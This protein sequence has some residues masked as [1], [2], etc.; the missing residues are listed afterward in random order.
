VVGKRAVND[1]GNPNWSARKGANVGGDVPFIIEISFKLLF[2]SSNM[3]AAGN[4]VS[5][6]EYVRTVLLNQFNYL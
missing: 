6:E 4:K 5:E 2:Q 1:G 3:I